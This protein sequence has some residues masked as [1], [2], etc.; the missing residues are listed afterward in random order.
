MVG[1]RV[2]G[3]R[4][5]TTDLHKMAEGRRQTEKTPLKCPKNGQ[6]GQEMFVTGHHSMVA[7]PH[8][9]EK[10]SKHVFAA[11]LQKNGQTMIKPPQKHGHNMV[12]SVFASLK[13][14][15]AE[16]RKRSPLCFSLALCQKMVIVF[17]CPQK[18]K[19]A[20]FRCPQ[21]KKTPCLGVYQWF[22]CL[23]CVRV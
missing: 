2:G 17:R 12:A 16:V 9:D 19:V 10:L 21:K 4:A 20:V 11:R 5:S 6:N 3:K 7:V 22:P 18:K 15:V 23:F 1:E 8:S 13:M 14:V